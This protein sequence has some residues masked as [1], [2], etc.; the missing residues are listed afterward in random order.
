MKRLVLALALTACA[1]AL[2]Q[3]PSHAPDM[4]RFHTEHLGADRVLV[5]QCLDAGSHARERVVQDVCLAAY[6]EDDRV[7][8]LERQC[9]WRA[10]AAWEDEMTV[11]LAKLRKQV[12]ARDLGASQREWQAS[13]L[14]D[15]G[16]GMDI[17]LGG[18]LEGPVGAHIRAR[19]EARRVQDLEDLAAMFE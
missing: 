18:S 8:A 4:W 5:R 2:A 15:V 13:M 16:M 17:A 7:P 14:A 3:T 6:G 10:M 12:N 1:P 9:D 11:T 19:A